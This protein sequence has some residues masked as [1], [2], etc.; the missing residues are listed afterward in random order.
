[1][2]NIQVEGL[3]DESIHIASA[4][5]LAGFS[6]VIGT[7]WTI[8]DC[9]S[10]RVSKDVYSIMVNDK[11]EIDVGRAAEG[12]HF[13]VRQLREARVEDSRSRRR[14]GEDP[15]VWASYIYLGA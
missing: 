7:L 8:N 10:A 15:L 11:G 6:H 3:L 1:M 5:Q 9:H 4:F 14:L 12:L 13:A 2:P